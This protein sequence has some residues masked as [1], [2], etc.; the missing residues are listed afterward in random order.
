MSRYNIFRRNRLYFPETSLTFITSV[1][2]K[3]SV[4]ALE[5]F[6]GDK[7]STTFVAMKEGWVGTKTYGIAN[8]QALAQNYA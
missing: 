8:K 3:D 5:Q 1:V 4:A 7:S 6:C 2:A